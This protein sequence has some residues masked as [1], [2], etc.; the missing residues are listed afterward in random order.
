MSPFDDFKVP[1][2]LSPQDKLKTTGGLLAQRTVSSKKA[3]TA[4]LDAASDVDSGWI[5]DDNLRAMDFDDRLN[6]D[7]D[8]VVVHDSS[9]GLAMDLDRERDDDVVNDFGFGTAASY[10]SPLRSELLLPLEDLSSSEV[11]SSFG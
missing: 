3:D 5:S 10:L 7:I 8:W 1:M 9:F 6:H 2:C 11:S 4:L